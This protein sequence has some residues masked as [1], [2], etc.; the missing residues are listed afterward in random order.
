MDILLLGKGMVRCRTCGVVPG[1]AKAAW[2][3]AIGHLAARIL[4]LSAAVA[5]ADVLVAVIVGRGNVAG[6][7]STVVFVSGVAILILGGVKGGAPRGSG[8]YTSGSEVRA[9]F[10]RTSPSLDAALLLGGLLLIAVGLIVH[11]TIG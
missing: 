4:I 6:A 11:Y 2:T 1:P 10:G 3:T 9:R 7:Y 8:V 5:V